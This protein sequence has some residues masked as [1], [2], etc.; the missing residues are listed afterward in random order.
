VAAVNQRL[1]DADLGRALDLERYAN[2][3]SRQALGL[4]NDVDEELLAKLAAA[5]EKGGTAFGIRRIEQL[6]ESVR[7]LNVRAYTKV[8]RTLITE[9]ADLTEVELDWQRQ[10]LL[11]EALAGLEDARAR[12]IRQAV[13]IGFLESEPIDAIVRRIRGTKAAGYA[14]GLLE[15]PR[16]HLE[17][18]VR[19]AVAHTANYAKQA[20][21]RA[22]EDIVKQW[23]VVATL[24]GRTPITCASLSGRKFPIGEGPQ[25]PRHWRCRSLASPVTKSWR[26]LGIPIDEIDEGTRASMDGQVPADQTFSAW[27]RARSAAVQDD[28]LGAT[29]AKLFRANAVEVAAFTNNKGLVYTLEQLRGRSPGLFAR[30]GL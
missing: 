8:Q 10:V 12:Q 19:T 24:D 20:H 16:H 18:V 15:A 9:L 4:L 23:V 27:L 14:D 6:L 21:Y 25:P 22:N 17:A 3:V 30:A 7:A 1:A 13:R 11:K 2:H 29:R 5:L 26:E 28:V